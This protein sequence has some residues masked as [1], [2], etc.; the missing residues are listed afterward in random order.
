MVSRAIFI[1]LICA[2][3]LSAIAATL[4]ISGTYGNPAGCTLARTNNYG[5]DDSARILRPDGVESMVTACSFHTVTTLAN[6]RHQVTMTC[7]SEGSGPED[8]IDASAENLR[9][10]R[11]RLCRPICRRHGLGRPEEM[12][13]TEPALTA[14]LR[15]FAMPHFD[16]PRQRRSNA[17]R[18]RRVMTDAE[19]KLWNELR[20]HRLMGLGFRRQM[21]ISHYIVDFACSETQVHRRS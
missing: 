15:N 1:G 4:P 16:V 13:V 20:A 3:P 5:E 10:H 12:P 17:K 21:P 18:M 2:A 19:L 14:V 11:I 9:R 8:N 7:A 6:G